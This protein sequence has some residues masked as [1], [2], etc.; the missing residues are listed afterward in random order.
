MD[1]GRREGHLSAKQRRDAQVAQQSSSAVCRAR[2]SSSGVHSRS[3][4]MGALSIIIPGVGAC[5][6]TA[7]EL[8]DL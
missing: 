6:R 5:A 3:N 1:A 2:D 4:I 8:N 7:Q